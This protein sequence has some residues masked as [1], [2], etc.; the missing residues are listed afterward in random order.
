MTHCQLL[1]A[2]P[3]R[4][5]LVA[6]SVQCGD[7]GR[8]EVLRSTRGQAVVCQVFESSGGVGQVGGGDAGRVGIWG[9]VW[10]PPEVCCKKITSIIIIMT[11]SVVPRPR[12][13]LP[14]HPGCSQT[15][16]D[17]IRTG[18]DRISQTV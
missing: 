8:V 1:D 17:Q 2:G 5:L 6:V 15:G 12:S 4:L 7:V 3:C 9:G 11:C 16:T 10:S 18:T 13:V 14:E